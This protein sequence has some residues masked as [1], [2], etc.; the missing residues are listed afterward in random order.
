VLG[1]L[2]DRVAAQ[3]KGD[4]A[5]VRNLARLIGQTDSYRPL[6][7]SVLARD[8]EKLSPYGVSY[9]ALHNLN[10]GVTQLQAAQELME[11]GPQRVVA[12][13]TLLRSSLEALAVALWILDSDE[14]IERISRTLAWFKHNVA[15][16]RVAFEDFVGKELSGDNRTADIRHI[17][18]QNSVKL[19]RVNARVHSTEALRFAD[20]SLDVPN[21]LLLY[22]WRL[23]SGVAHGRPWAFANLS[24]TAPRAPGAGSEQLVLDEASLRVP[25]RIAVVL[26]DAVI[27]AFG[28]RTEAGPVPPLDTPDMG[29]S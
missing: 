19:S 26:L 15:D 9:A 3:W 21:H 13:A 29:D 6:P 14:Q 22:I 18:R 5:K 10:T 27:V 17:A 23:C 7:G 16:E 4:V 20:T 28:E 11:K 25:F 1:L 24:S 8:D 12:A 2:S